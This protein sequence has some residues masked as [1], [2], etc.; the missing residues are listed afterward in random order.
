[1]ARR[2]GRTGIGALVAVLLVVNAAVVVAR[3]GTEGDTKSIQAG[4]ARP[5]S[6]GSEVLENGEPSTTVAAA[7]ATASVSPPGQWVP[8]T[9]TKPRPSSTTTPTTR[10]STTTSTTA[11]A[12]VAGTV[13]PGLHVVA[14]DG[15]GLVRLTDHNGGMFAWAPDGTRLAQSTGRELIIVRADGSGRTTL[16]AAH[17][18][19]APVWSPD[20]RLIAFGVP[21]AGVFVA[22]T[23]GSGTATL[24][25]PKGYLANWT[26]DN[27]L[28]VLT[29][30]AVGVDATVVLYDLAGGRRVLATRAGTSVDPAPSP[31]GRLVAYATD[32]IMVAAMDG[33]GARPLTGQCCGSDI[34]P[35]PQR[36]S[37]DSS[38]LLFQHYGDVW[39]VGAGGGN[40]RIL[41]EKAYSPA[42]SPDGR[43]VAITD[44][45]SL[46][47]DGLIHGKVAVMPAGGGER[48]TVYDPGQKLGVGQPQWSP[49]G[50]QIAMIVTQ[51]SLPFPP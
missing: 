6:L 50:R 7:P 30:A 23:D 26:Q 49:N 28:V 42:W 14:P 29:H 48:R 45:R 13:G 41:A 12:P 24:V 9:T 3:T 25:D 5:A 15:T 8:T 11:P 22:R 19:G 31:D 43:S 1:M 4:S 10:P 37:P 36:W 38:H 39:V 35:W 47:A 2:A 20:G 44:G 34:F 27:R 21:E 33:S 32:R 46:R 17:G 16:P 18:A 51:F 40:D